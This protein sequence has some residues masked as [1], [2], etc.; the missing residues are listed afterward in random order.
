MNERCAGAIEALAW[1]RHLLDSHS[2][3]H[4]IRRELAAAE[5]ELLNGVAVDFRERIRRFQ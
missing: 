2:D 4:R 5:D 1:F 3:L